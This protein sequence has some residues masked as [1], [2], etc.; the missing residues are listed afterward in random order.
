MGQLQNNAVVVLSV[1]NPF[2]VVIIIPT[3][4]FQ[5]E[6]SSWRNSITSAFAYVHFSLLTVPSRDSRKFEQV[7]AD[8]R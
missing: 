8:D 6:P 4:L 1:Q 7:R 5:C 3:P 2:H